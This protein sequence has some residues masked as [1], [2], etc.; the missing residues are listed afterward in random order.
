MKRKYIAILL[1]I[2]FAAIS[3]PLSRIIWPDPVGMVGPEPQL[4]PFFIVLSIL[5]SVAL[6]VGMVILISYFSEGKKNMWTFLAAVWLLISWWPHDN[7]HRVNG[8][9]NFFG[10]LM[11]EYGFHITLMISGLILATFVV[12]KL[13]E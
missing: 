12:R 10:L 3:F 8:D 2:I 6:G 7:L 1:A 5:E 4:I 11:I 9:S 13:T